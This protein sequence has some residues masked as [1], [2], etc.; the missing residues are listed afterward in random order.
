M[1]TETRKR[2]SYLTPHE[3]RRLDWACH[4]IAKRFDDLPYLVGS[5]MQRED[6]RDIDIR[7]ILPDEQLAAMTGG[8][9]ERHY[10]LNVA[11]T[12]FIESMVRLRKPIDFQ[13]QSATE[14][15]TY[16]GDRNPLGMR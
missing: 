3:L 13:F 8:N 11:F 7:L 5:C 16:D 14:A 10:L 6:F 12:T 2:C 9:Q 15:A 1:A 4:P